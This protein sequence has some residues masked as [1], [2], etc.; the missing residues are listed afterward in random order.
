MKLLRLFIDPPKNN[1]VNKYQAY[2]YPEE[3]K[4]LFEKASLLMTPEQANKQRAILNLF[5]RNI[6]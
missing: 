4:A 3:C 5:V 6:F 2:A 1:T